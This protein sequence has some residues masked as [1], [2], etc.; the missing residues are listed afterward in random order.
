MRLYDEVAPIDDVMPMEE[1]MPLTVVPLLVDWARLAVSRVESAIDWFAS[2]SCSSVGAW[3]SIFWWKE[4]ESLADFY[5]KKACICSD[6]N[7]P[8]KRP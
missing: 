8:V 1:V 5:I 2:F 7:H 3:L 4:N 6:H